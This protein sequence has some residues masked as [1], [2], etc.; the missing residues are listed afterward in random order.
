MCSACS[1]ENCKW[2]LYPQFRQSRPKQHLE[3]LDILDFRPI[4]LLNVERKLFFS[5]LSK[6]LKKHIFSN[7][8]INPSIQKGYM[9]TVSGCWR[10]IS[11]VWDE[12]KLKKAEKSNITAIWLDIANVYGSVPHQLLFLPSDNIVFQNTGCSCLLSIMRACGVPA[13]LI[14]LLLVGTI[15]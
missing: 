4:S 9:E 6:Q 11:V 12:F 15:T 8:L 10:H 1:L 7:N 2:V 3:H 13:S 14:R 5:I